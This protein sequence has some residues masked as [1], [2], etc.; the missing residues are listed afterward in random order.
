[1][2]SIVVTLLMLL[3]VCFA[4]SQTQNQGALVGTVTDSSGAVV[5]GAKVTVTNVATSIASTIATDDQGAYR[6]SFLAPGNYVISVGAPGFRKVALQSVVVAVGTVTRTDIKLQVGSANDEVT[7]T[8]N[9]DVVSTENAERGDVLASEQIQHLPLNGRE[10]LQLA[11]L[12]PGA[13][14]GNPKRGVHAS[15]NGVDVSFNGS[16]GTTNSYYIN[17]AASNDP[18]YNTLAS[19]PALDAV[20]EFRVLTNMYS[21]QYGRAGGAVVT[22]LT[23]SGSNQFHGTAYEYHRNKALDALPYFY[24]GDRSKFANY[25]F[26]QYGGTIGGPVIKKKTFFFFSAEAFHQVKPGQL[27]VSF[28]PTAAERNGDVSN[29]INPFSL[30]P[31]VLTN[32]Y[33]QQPIPG[34]VLP[35][36]LKSDV[37][38]FLMSLWPQPNYNGDP[39]LNRHDFRGGLYTQRKY[40]V[41]IDH[42]FSE[43]DMITGTWDRNNYDNVSPGFNQYADKKQVDHTTTWAGTWT[44]TFTPRLVNDVKFATSSLQSGGQFVLTDNGGNFC[45]KWGFDKALN[46][47]PGTCR[48]LFYTIGYQRYDIGN[49]GDYKHHNDS[50]YLKNNVVW[51][52]GRHTLSFGGEWTRDTYNWQYDSGSTAYY[53]GVY[54]GLPGY[55]QYYNITGSTFTDVLT[56][57]SNL[58]NV[59]IGGTGGTPT[60][61]HLLRNVWSG[62]T[63]DDWKIKPRLTLNL[64]LRYD[65][66]Q[67][68]ANTDNEFMTLDFNTGLPRYAKGAPANLLSLVRFQYEANGPNRPYDPSPRNFSPRFGFALRPF[69]TNNTVIKGGYGL[70]YT[71]ET[72][73]TTMYGTWVAPFQGLV[74]MTPRYAASWPDSQM[75]L[76]RVDQPTPTITF[77][78]TQMSAL[79]YKRG[80]SPGIFFPNAPYYPTGYAQQYNLT[81]G[82][83]FGQ[84]WGAEAAYVGSHSVNL[85]GAMSTQTYDPILYAKTVAN[86]FSN[87]SLR[88]KGFNAHYDAMQLTLKRAPAHGYNLLATY[89]WS[90]ALAEASNDDSLENLITDVN[91]NGSIIKKLWS[92]ADFDVRHRFTI[93]GGYDLPFGKGKSFG[94]GW[95]SVIDGILGGWRAN[96]IFTYQTGVPFT[97]YTSGLQLPDRICSGILSRGTRN[98]N[99]W[100]DPTCFPSHVPTTI[101]DPVT[102]KPKT[103]NIQGNSKPNIIPGPPTNDIDFGMEKYIHITER[104]ML[105][106]RAEAFNILNHPNLI[107]PSGNYFFNS[108]S[109]A[110][111]TRARDGRDV[112]LAIRYSF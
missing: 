80:T 25:L 89:T 93:S 107:G 51:V 8:A 90:H 30:K 58:V 4:W 38:K 71:T 60:N 18:L 12:E 82:H 84:N 66:E 46:T 75:H 1:M 44:H 57:I 64:G 97:V 61:M 102:G 78:G 55:D 52:K 5:A 19:S 37:G 20:A 26:N 28:A 88:A 15:K 34:N 56:G 112:Q 33:T 24:T 39:F 65:Y 47:V 74:S 79:D 53:F 14:S 87:F 11:A 16:R 13:V 109:G 70:F 62:Y 17:G 110:K 100:Y 95:N 103:I 2:K 104:H 67:P 7:V 41:R 94:S 101:T 83:S 43:R 91:A 86:G 68:F 73:F 29:T 59:G 49:D 6:L 92:N 31:V 23:K 40:T 27:I 63:Q 77:Q 36:S 81:L 98:A 69:E 85:N 22:V 72:A 99:A 50:I 32:P 45:A 96:G 54:E 108:P 9:P 105:Q 111:I 42:H 21:A 35:D 76:F 48:I 10:F 3:L 106:L